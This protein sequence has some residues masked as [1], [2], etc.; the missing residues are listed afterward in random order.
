MPERT[1]I[2]C[3]RH[4]GRLMPR[5]CVKRWRQANGEDAPQYKDSR[6]T[7][8]GCP[9][10]EARSPSF[11]YIHLGKMQIQPKTCPDCGE[12]FT[13]KGNAQL[14]CDKCRPKK[15]PAPGTTYKPRKG[16]AP[17]ARNCYAMFLR[18][19]PIDKLPPEEQRLVRREAEWSQDNQA[20]VKTLD[21]LVGGKVALVREFKPIDGIGFYPE[22]MVLQ[23]VA[24]WADTI[25]GY[26][27]S[28]D[29][30]LSL[31]LNQIREHAEA[32]TE[33]EEDAI[34]EAGLPPAH[35]SSRAR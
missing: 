31:K 22:G 32:E 25:I 10:G 28:K 11:G 3:E 20:L 27:P 8:V 14:R 33:E 12:S 4:L 6:K 19:T 16:P 30:V 2:S 5:T 26:S 1:M 35:Q 18:S 21:A 23:V 34:L 7:C 15:G 24:R 13:P 9:H 29:Q 17:N